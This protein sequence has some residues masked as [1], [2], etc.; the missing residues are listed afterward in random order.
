VLD[1]HPAQRLARRYNERRNV[2]ETARIGSY[3]DLPAAVD[4]MRRTHGAGSSRA[5]S[6]RSRPAQVK[7]KAAPPDNSVHSESQPPSVRRITSR[8]NRPPSSAVE[9]PIRYA[10]W[11]ENTA[12][13]VW[14]ASNCVPSCVRTKR[15]GL[16]TSQIGLRRRID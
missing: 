8:C 4:L 16:F 2:I 9:R 1:N 15:I 5:L 10:V 6:C 14:S 3:T 13:A 7:P 12:A 11:V